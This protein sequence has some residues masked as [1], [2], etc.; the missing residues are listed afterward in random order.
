MKTSKT[1]SIVSVVAGAG[2]GNLTY[3]V[4]V[5]NNGLCS[6]VESCLVESSGKRCIHWS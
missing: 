4:T 6:S 2:A 1:V 5:I 3:I